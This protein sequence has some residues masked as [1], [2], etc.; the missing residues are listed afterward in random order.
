MAELQDM[1]L[2]WGDVQNTA[3]TGKRMTGL[4][5]SRHEEDR[6]IGIKGDKP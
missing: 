6:Y 3:S 4:M 5:L 2:K 1:R